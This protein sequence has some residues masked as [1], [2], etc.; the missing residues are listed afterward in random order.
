MIEKL[1]KYPDKN[2][3]SKRDEITKICKAAF[4]ETLAK[5]DFS[6]VFKRNGL[7]IKLDGS[8]DHLVSNKLKAFRS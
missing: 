1:G 3:S 4:A 2:P 5:V 6:D 7:A 8:E